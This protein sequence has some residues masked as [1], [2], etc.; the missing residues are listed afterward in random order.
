M[1][2]D[3][4]NSNVSTTGSDQ[5]TR[6]QSKQSNGS[7]VTTKVQDKANKIKNWIKYLPIIGQ[8]LLI[9]FFVMIIIGLVTLF[10]TLPGT[11]IE[12]IKEFGNNL[13]GGIV[14]FFS[15]DNI[16]ATVTKEDQI[17]LAQRIQDMGYDIV[18]YGFAD[19]SYQYDDEP[20]ASE[21][22][23]FTNGTITSISTLS[24]SRNYLQ[25]YIAQS[26]ATYRLTN[27]SILGELRSEIN[28]IL[29]LG[30]WLLGN[31]DSIPE[32]DAKAYSQGLLNVI[33]PGDDPNTV[34]IEGNSPPQI[35]VDRE[36]K[37]LRIQ[38]HRLG[39]NNALS[40][41]YGET[42][43]FDLS[44]WTSLYGKPLELFLALHISTMM[45]D[46]AYDFATED[47]FNTKV[48]IELQEVQSTYKV[49]YRNANG[50]EILQEDIEKIVLQAM[51]GLS[52]EQIDRFANAGK[53]DDLYR[54]A[55]LT[56]EQV[57]I[58]R[59]NV[60][61]NGTLDET[62][63]SELHRAINITRLE[64]ELL[65]VET[66]QEQTKLHNVTRTY[67]NTFVSEIYGEQ[68]FIDEE[69]VDMDKYVSV[70]NLNVSE[71]VDALVSALSN[72][73]LSGLNGEQIRDL[74]ELMLDG[75][76]ESNTY[77]PRI[78]SVTNHW[79]YEDIEFRYGTAG[80]AKKKVQYT[81]D[82][83]DDPLSETNLN[84]A[85][86][87]LD[88][89]YTN[90]SGVFYQLA[91]PEAIGPNDAIK[92]LFKGGSGK[93]S[94]TS[95]NF[96]GEYYRYDG[97]RATAQKIARAKAIDEGRST[98]TFQGKQLSVGD[99]NDESMNVEKQKVTFAT[100][101]ENGNETF[102]DAYTAFAILE[103]VHTLEA[104]TVYR[105][106]KEL[107]V[108][109]EYFSEEDFLKPLNQVLLWPV[110]RVGSDTEEYDDN[111]DSVTQGIYRDENQYGLF[112]ENGTAVNTGDTII[113][114]GDATIVK[115][116]GDAITL[117]FKS[118]SDGQAEALQAKFGEDYS[119]VDRDIVLDMEMTIKGVNSSVSV[120]QEVTA[121]IQIGSATSDDMRIIMYNLDKS[122][123]E[124]IETYMYPTYDGTRPIII[125]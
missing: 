29:G 108:D 76:V 13:W 80:K 82:S 93:L 42:Y 61:D 60:Q 12:N 106:L 5:E 122:Y 3:Q 18:G 59:I 31:A 119:E 34:K 75:V 121:G 46:L 87:I 73:I 23:G 41:G 6:K 101:D 2:E 97:T 65:G 92:A 77:L 69:I 14:G 32:K 81:T 63:T 27:W 85:S 90:A 36:N 17:A 52:A 26:E 123:V 125:L 1:G 103:N 39:I 53:L 110:E 35:R 115:V 20:N 7:G 70:V 56:P 120:G 48:N 38:T 64:R 16:T 47:C 40:I 25:A 67:Y 33:V 55:M 124:D 74:I 24:D 95:Y 83:E 19:A 114:P 99:V 51:T 79:F 58:N 45:P 112:L 37:L 28:S 57:S 62:V 111:A 15:G 88:T 96:T 107:V 4:D 11:Y 84:G 113:A 44:D 30:D 43:Y 117:K 21:I 72:T 100:K 22:D 50:E 104:E 68:Q 66:G 109:L 91:E 8:V 105:L 10:I 71:E 78:T 94:E 86:I 54:E 116:D 9:V 118:I 98:Y 102:N 49:I 89:T